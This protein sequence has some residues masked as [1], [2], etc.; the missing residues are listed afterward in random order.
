M[1]IKRH[2]TCDHVDSP[3]SDIRVVKFGM[4]VGLY[5]E[6]SIGM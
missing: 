1:N 4:H 3:S 2:F 5:D 6:L